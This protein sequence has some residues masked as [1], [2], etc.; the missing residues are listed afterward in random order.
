MVTLSSR[1]GG[2]TFYPPDH[3]LPPDNTRA[4]P[5]RAYPTRAYPTTAYPTRAYPTRAYPTR[6]YPTTAYPSSTY[7]S[8]TTESPYLGVSVCVRYMAVQQRSSFVWTLSPSSR[9]A[10]TLATNTE[11]S[12]LLRWQNL[13]YQS[14]HLDPKI[15]IWPDVTPDI[16]TRVC[17]TV[18]TLR[19]VAQIFRD[20]DMSVRTILPLKFL[21]SGEPVVAMS[22][23]DG[24]V[25]DLQVWDYPLS[26]FV[27]HNYMN[28]RWLTGS[29]LTWSNI[30]YSLSGSTLVELVYERRQ[31]K[32]AGKKSRGRRPQKPRRSGK[33]SL[34]KIF[35]QAH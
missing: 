9:G 7:P 6:A 34:L 2:V 3:S 33:N 30:R 1:G 19:S 27:I 16:W 11:G 24:Q 20:A 4:Y 23:F 18:D 10:M 28:N 29:V 26:Y 17:V 15:K 5:T 32:R 13:Q 21:W 25:T 22:Y 31:E 8:R 14:V 35:T 12:Y